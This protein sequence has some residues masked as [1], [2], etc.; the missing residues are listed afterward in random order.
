L[1]SD[2]GRLLAGHCA[3]LCCAVLV[4]LQ[5]PADAVNLLRKMLELNPAKRIRAIDALFV[6]N[7]SPHLIKY[8]MLIWSSTK[9]QKILKITKN[10]ILSTGHKTAET[11]LS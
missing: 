3:V 9:N 10:Q 6:S 5:L 2:K 4:W 7:A 1:R 11:A 8:I